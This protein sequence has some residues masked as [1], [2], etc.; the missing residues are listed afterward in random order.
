MGVGIFDSYEL[1]HI[2][3]VIAE[4]NVKQAESVIL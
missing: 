1:L 4:E 3:V 2:S